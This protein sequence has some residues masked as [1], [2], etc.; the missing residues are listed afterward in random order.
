[1]RKSPAA[2]LRARVLGLRKALPAAEA[3]KRSH[4]VARTFLSSS[5]ARTLLSAPPLRIAVYRSLPALGEFDLGEVA[6]RLAE[7]GHRL[8]YPRVQEGD[9]AF[10]EVSPDGPFEKGA[11]GLEEPPTNRPQVR[12]EEIDLFFVPGVVF[13]RRGERIGLGKGYYD[14][15][16][17]QA[18]AAPRLALAFGFQLRDRVPQ[19]A[20]DARLD[21]VF[22]ARRGY[23]APGAAARLRRLFG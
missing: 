15:L 20:G 19:W 14:R 11:F 12:P 17:A 21:L 18:P 3:R 2:A 23:L 22:T 6:H 10:Y 4:A 9:L 13:G 16:L 7:R 1:M 8:C 5:W